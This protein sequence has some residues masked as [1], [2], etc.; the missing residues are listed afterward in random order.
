MMIE[1][2]GI[3]YTLIGAGLTIDRI[4]DIVAEVIR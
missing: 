3:I 2:L 4:I 1:T